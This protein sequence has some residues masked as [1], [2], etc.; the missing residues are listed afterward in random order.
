MRRD[1]RTN[2]AAR[3]DAGPLVWAG[4]TGAGVVAVVLI[5]LGTMLLTQPEDVTLGGGDTAPTMDV[6]LSVCRALDEINT[7]AKEGNLSGAIALAESERSGYEGTEYAVTFAARIDDLRR[8]RTMTEIEFAAKEWLESV[9]VLREAGRTQEAFVKAHDG[10]GM[11]AN[12][13]SGPKIARELAALESIVNAEAKAAG[14]LDGVR[15]HADELLAKAAAK[16]LTRLRALMADAGRID[17]AIAAA[18]IAAKKYSSTQSAKALAD[19]A[20]TLTESVAERDAARKAISVKW[21][22]ARAK[23]LFAEKEFEKAACVYRE[24][25]RLQPSEEARKGFLNS[26]FALHVAQSY[27][28]EKADDMHE[29]MDHLRKALAIRSDDQ[30]HKRLARLELARGI[31]MALR[32]AR[33]LW[34]DD[35]LIAAR[36]TYANV[37]AAAPEHRKAAIKAEINA[38]IAFDAAMADARAAAATE[39][40]SDAERAA[41]R[42]LEAK[43]GEWRARKLI[44]TAKAALATL[45]ETHAE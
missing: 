36:M 7:L 24:L 22:L 35:Q 6:A 34:R 17:D 2:D 33:G 28:M 1:L 8:A 30:V 10:E 37:L 41:K 38:A 39:R 21:M 18:R 40:W 16:E 14:K 23:T 42:A 29:A 4:A 25:G 26:R 27:E 11:F 9:R 13:T 19:L 44:K 3:R 45:D 43:P 20:A 31:D 12:S 15:T 5:I 32:M